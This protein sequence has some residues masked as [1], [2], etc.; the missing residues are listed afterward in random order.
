MLDKDDIIYQM[1]KCNSSSRHIGYRK[2][3]DTVL[4]TQLHAVIALLRWMRLGTK[5][6]TI[7]LHCSYRAKRKQFYKAQNGKLYT[8]VT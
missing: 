3:T 7:Y 8:L 5:Y 1:T 2:Q 6:V 4:K